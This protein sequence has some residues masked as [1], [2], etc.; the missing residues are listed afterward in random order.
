MDG[1]NIIE[2]YITK[3]ARQ[4]TVGNQKNESLI[5]FPILSGQL[6]NHVYTSNRKLT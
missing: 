6:L 3:I 1:V 5:D 4:R 2:V